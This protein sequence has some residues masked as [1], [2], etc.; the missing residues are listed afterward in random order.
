MSEAE[1]SYAASKG[2]VVTT[3]S[4]RRNFSWTMLGNVYYAGCQWAILAMLAKF[5]NTEMVGEFALAMAIAGPAI[6]FANLK[7]RAVQASDAKNEYSFGEYLGLR[8]VTTPLALFAIALIV[9]M[10]YR[11]DVGTVILLVGL[12]KAFETI[13]D[14]IFGL[15]QQREHMKQIAISQVLK[16]TISLVVF[17]FLILSTESLALSVAGLATS[18][19]FVLFVYD[20]PLA[21]GT[22]EESS[23]SLSKGLTRN[24]RKLSPSWN[25]K[26]LRQLLWRTLP[27]GVTVLIGSLSANIPRYFIAGEKGT[28]QLGL[29][30]GMSYI[31]VAGSLVVNALGQSATPRLANYYATSNYDAFKSLLN[32]LILLGTILGAIGFLAAVIA[33]KQILTLIYN[34]EYAQNHDVFIWITVDAA[35]GYTYVFLGTACSAMRKFTVQLPIHIVTLIALIVLSWIWVG[36]FGAKGAAWALLGSGVLEAIAYIVVVYFTLKEATKTKHALEGPD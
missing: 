35:V 33:G 3:L 32:K 5:G 9:A 26:R 7:L 8:L 23:V 14:I 16:G 30:A 19:A 28:S 29:F 2:G 18:W 36:E 12:A 17:G 4:L 34:N 31:L 10:S 15:F 24:I 25:A 21:I 6:V 13:S 20:L 27:L 1:A 22:I 11:S